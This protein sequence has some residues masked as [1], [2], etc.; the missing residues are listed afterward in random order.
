MKPA[1]IGTITKIATTIITI[2][3]FNNIQAN[4]LNMYVK[5]NMYSWISYRKDEGEIESIIRNKAEEI[6]NE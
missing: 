1:D 6:I 4:K 2:F 5:D 3:N